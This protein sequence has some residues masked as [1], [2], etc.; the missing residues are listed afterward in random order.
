MTAGDI[1]ADLLLTACPV[2][3]L[4]RVKLP[5]LK[6]LLVLVVFSAS[7][8]TGIVAIFCILTVYGPWARGPSGTI[9]LLVM[10]H[11][12]V[13]RPAKF[14]AAFQILTLHRQGRP[15]SL[16]TLRWWSPTFIVYSDRVETSKQTQQWSRN[17]FQRVEWE[18][19]LCLPNPQLC[20]PKSRIRRLEIQKQR[21]R[22]HLICDDAQVGE[23][24]T[25]HCCQV[26]D[27]G[28]LAVLSPQYT[29]SL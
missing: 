19:P 22:R 8:L 12:E 21:V 4:W 23:A 3:A 16:P 14:T 18:E 9:L 11:V 29:Y 25:V 20:S 5:V 13:R 6:R 2:Y 24:Y 1:L 7:A 17:G 26:Y 28:S 10:P 15:S 27:A